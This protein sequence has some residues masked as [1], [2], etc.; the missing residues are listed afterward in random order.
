VNCWQGKVFD[1]QRGKKSAA[2]AVST[3]RKLMKESSEAGAKALR[4]FFDV[5]GP[6]E[7]VPL[8]QG[9]PD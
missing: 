2:K 8:L 6:A 5:Y 3:N 9:L 7:A 1:R 4:S